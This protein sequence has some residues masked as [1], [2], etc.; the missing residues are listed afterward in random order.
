[1]LFEMIRNAVHATVVKHG[2]D[3]ELHPI[4]VTIV[5][6]PRLL[7]VRVSDEGGGLSPYGGLPPPPP[8]PLPMHGTRYGPG[9]ALLPSQILPAHVESAQRLDIFSFSHMRRF[10]QHHAQ[11]LHLHDAG[12]TGATAAGT[13]DPSLG[14]SGLALDTQASPSANNDTRTT[15]SASPGLSKDQLTGIMAL[16]TIGKL[17]GTV[18]EQLAE[19]E[20]SAA[21]TK[22]RDDEEAIRDAQM[23]SGI[24]LP[25][26]KMFAEWV[27]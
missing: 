3:A 24:G 6:Q 9:Q 21:A 2:A 13:L 1:M 26:A 11:Q 27:L 7:S 23:K 19:S 22:D 15:R 5:H 18:S 17:S 16:R 10:Y 4:T 14:S 25:L 8:P 12:A 20:S